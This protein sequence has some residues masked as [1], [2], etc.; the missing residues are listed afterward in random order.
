MNC[1]IHNILF[2]SQKQNSNYTAVK[3]NPLKF[4]NTKIRC[5]LKK[6]CCL[7]SVW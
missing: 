7:Q 6:T 2:K 4:R 1:S 5:L 3:K